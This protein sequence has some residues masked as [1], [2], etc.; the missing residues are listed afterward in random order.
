MATCSPLYSEQNH[1]SGSS[2]ENFSIY[3]LKIGEGKLSR[4]SDANCWTVAL[5]ED[6]IVPYYANE[7]NELRLIKLI[8]TEKLTDKNV[9]AYFKHVILCPTNLT[10][11]DINNQIISD[12][13]EG[14]IHSYFSVDEVDADESLDLPIES[15]HQL[16]PSGYPPHKLKL[17][18]G[19]IV[20]VFRN[21]STNEGIVNGTRAI[22]THLLKT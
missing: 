7:D 1:A 22:V 10:V 19:T 21:L 8:F 17:K 15:I 20:I 11:M 3:L 13:L 12:I 2:S 18:L 6:I 16:L 4:V 14:D 9:E 5:C